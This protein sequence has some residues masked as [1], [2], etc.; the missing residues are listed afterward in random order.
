MS[1]LISMQAPTQ[2]QCATTTHDVFGSFTV[3]RIVKDEVAFSPIPN[4]YNAL[5]KAVNRLQS[6][7]SVFF[8]SFDEAEE[9]L[10]TAK[11]G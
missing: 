2:L 7:K 3:Q 5:Q 4:P 6:G 10:A 8:E 9:Q 11:H 1:A